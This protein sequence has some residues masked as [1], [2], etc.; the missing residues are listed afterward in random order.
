[1]P[2]TPARPGQWR[3]APPQVGRHSR[4]VP[5]R[6][7]LA[8]ARA[9]SVWRLWP[10]AILTLAALA[11][12]G[13]YLRVHRPPPPPPKPLQAIHQ[14]AAR[15]AALNSISATFTTQLNGLTVAFG[16]VQEELRPTPLAAFAMTTVDGAD[17]FAVHE[18]V[19]NTEVYLAIPALAQAT[20]KP[21]AGVPVAELTADPALAE[22]YQTIAI[23]TGQAGLL[24]VAGDARLAG[25]ATIGRVRT[26]RYVGTL[27]PAA[28]AGRSLTLGRLLAPELKSVSGQIS[29]VA[30]IDGR[31]NFREIQT[32]A[33]IGGQ[34]TVTTIVYTA[35]N[36]AV[37]TAV[38]LASQ[39]APAPLSG[40]P[41]S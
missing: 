31:H 15:S 29:F 2:G 17:R 10:A 12:G 20:G 5:S 8:R 3:E 36:Q 4:T 6:Q 32:T 7:P 39:V 14:A 19:N 37:Q 18:I 24:A 25:S 13:Y 34:R 11:A 35:A 22:L 40:L 30:W 26:S 1:M 33:T 9:R 41:T 21:W 27:D 23:P 16:S 38:P 28:L